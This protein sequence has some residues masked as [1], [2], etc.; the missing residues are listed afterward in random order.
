MATLH[1]PHFQLN[2]VIPA[3]YTHSLVFIDTAVADYQSLI[4]GVI[5]QTEIFVLDST[6][7]GVEQITEILATRAD[8]NIN[9]IHIVCHGTPGNLQLGNAHLGLDTLEDHSQQLQQWQK[10]FSASTKDN[11]RNLLIYGCNVAFSDVGAEFIAKL[12]QLTGANIAASRQL[13]GSAA[14]GG[15]W[16]LEV[17]TAQMEV[18]LAFAE[19]TQ[20]AYAGVLA[21]FTV[22]DTGDTDDG[23]ANNGITT[24]REAINLANATAGDDAIAF[25]RIFTDTTPD[26]ITL[27]SGQLTI[28]DDVTILGTG[29]SNL[30]VSGGNNA[31]TVFEI[32]GLATG[33]SINGLAIASG[34]IKVNRNSILSL[35]NTSVSG[36]TAESGISNSGILSLANTSVFGNTQGGIYNLGSLTLTGSS[37]YGNSWEDNRG[38]GI[39]NDG[40]NGNIGTL[41]LI[42]SSV[43]GNTAYFGGGI[44]SGGTLRLTNSTVSGNTALEDGG[45]IYNAGVDYDAGS[46]ILINATI[47]GNTALNDGGGIYNGLAYT[48]DNRLTLINNTIN[49]NT[50]D[51]DGDGAGNGGGVFSYFRDSSYHVKVNNTIIA[52]NLD[53]S[54]SGD[55]DPDVRGGLIDSGNNLIGNNTGSTA[56]TTSTLVGTSASPIDPKLGLLQNNGGATFT[57]ALLAGSPA[58]DAG[59][60]SLTPA[61]ITTDQRGAGFR[62]IFNGVVDIGAY[63]VQT[64]T[65]NPPVVN[66]DTFVV[67]NTND[68]G[69]GSLRQAILNANATL[70]ADTITFAG[71]FTD[72]TPDIITLTSGKLTITDDITILGTGASNLTISGNNLSGVFEISGTGTDASIDGLKIANA[73]DPLGSILLNTNTSLSLTGSTVSDNTGLVGGIFNK[74][75]LSLTNTTVSGNSGS[76]LGGGIFNKGN[77]SLTNSNVS[78]NSAYVFSNTAYGG[79]IF[80]TGNLN[81][82]DSTISNNSAFANGE[83]HG[84]GPNPYPSSGGGIYNSGSVDI[85]RSTVSNNSAADGGGISNSGTFSLIN[86]TVS[87]NSVYYTGGGILNSGALTLTNDTITSNTA[88][89]YV[90]EIGNGGGVVSNGG[91]VIVGNTIIAGNFFNVEP[92]YPYDL[93]GYSRDV[94]GKFTDAGNNLIG[95]N[96]ASTGLTTSTLVGTRTN[97][98][99]PK[100][101]PLQNNGGTTLTN[102]LIGNSPAINAGNNALIPPGITTDQRGTGFDRISQ[103][104]VD[105]GALEFNGLNGSNGA[106]NLVGKNYSDIINAQA[107]NDTIT[108]NQGNDILTGGGGKDKFIYNLG[109]GVDTITDFGGLGK[110]SNPS[111]A[112]ISELDTLKFQGS[113]LTAQNLLLTKNGNNLEVTFEGVADDK[114]ILQNF[115]LENLD[116]LWTLGNILFDGQSSIRDSFDVF[117]ANS[118]QTS[119]FNKNTVTFLNNLNNNVNGFE[120]SGDVIN[121]EGGDDRIDGLSGNDL[122]R[123]GEGNDTLLGSEG[124]DTLVGS[125]G[126]DSLIGGAG[127]DILLG[128]GG[129]DTLTGG[130]G[131]DQFIYQILSNNNSTITDFKQSQDKLVFTNLFKSQGYSS[132]NP[133]GDGHLKFVQSGTSTL[134]EVL[135]SYYPGY[136]SFSTFATLDNFTATNLVVGSN[137][138]V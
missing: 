25:G 39:Y 10:I 16:E 117:D 106:D 12:H 59:K 125:L 86:S 98:I 47:S 132:S 63:E 80:N 108:G 56:F 54:T 111:A 26:T 55:I 14:L 71:V 51:S 53:N 43:S 3:S 114:I 107:G 92:D 96:T 115:T 52:G 100:L 64:P 112:V 74:G 130:S 49:N 105:I 19:T 68:S 24:L 89:G 87:D 90:G 48:S 126:N 4:N 6:K 66:T 57:Q 95:D 101:S 118:T 40:S 37:V 75:T 11:P 9:S 137:V 8:Q 21:T 116:N 122:L 73:N 99:D 13:I 32:S 69:A 85:T 61:R 134:V 18:T 133:I 82:T 123:G 15:N 76:S 5:S 93:S 70:G 7:N 46:A 42:D 50:A 79:G 67:N 103:G 136:S 104:T 91:T 78:N 28:T 84:I 94:S 36:N 17:R 30:T 1:T 113:G 81:I 35:A 97:P 109:D 72:A 62:R 23:D 124:N 127:D 129:S 38:G 110:G 45:G 77:F 31:S 135:I 58:I 128:G 44:Y 22:N 120:N 60:N 20:K 121:G 119:I 41:S 138:I 88:E 65:T 33:V 102:A 34:G 2:S 27:T 83:S 131:N 29:I